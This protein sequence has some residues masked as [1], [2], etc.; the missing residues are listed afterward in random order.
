MVSFSFYRELVLSWFLLCAVAVLY[1][2]SRDCDADAV[3]VSRQPFWRKR[4]EQWRTAEKVATMTRGW[5]GAIKPH[6]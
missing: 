1:T 2:G 4:T 5:A 6:N 3:L